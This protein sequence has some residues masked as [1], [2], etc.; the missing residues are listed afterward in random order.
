MAEFSIQDVAFTGF[1]VVRE[2]P[3]ALGVWA[4]YAMA[5]SV[6]FA[7]IL[8]GMMG[9][10][11]NQLLAAS[12]EQPADPAKVVALFGRIGPAYFL[13]LIVA[14]ALNAILGA[15]MIRAVLH[16]SD[17]RFGFLRLGADEG[18]QLVLA[19]IT[20]LFFLGVYLGFVV[21]VSI[22][23]VIAALAAKAAGA[24]VLVLGLV[25]GGAGMVVLAVRLSLA[26][27]LTFET[28]RINLLGS[29]ALTR[30]RFW[31]I[32]GAYLLTFGLV[33]VVYFL[34]LLVMAAAGAVLAGGDLQAVGKTPDTSSLQ[35]YFTLNTLVQSVL[36][37]FVSALVWPVLFTPAAAIYRHLSAPAF[38]S[39]DVFS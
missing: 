8:V 20:A 17:D 36:S 2:H 24:L 14:I 1:R 23:S 21:A 16:P 26:P 9:P 22:L 25:G 31:R 37:A 15:A 6:I 13:F 38:A 30:G 35:A 39:A 33:M 10:D 3:K 34:S 5:L 29:W 28:G 32:F 27:S 12:R 18:R 4:A 19:F 7:V 11:L